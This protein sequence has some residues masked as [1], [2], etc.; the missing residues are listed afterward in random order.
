MEGGSLAV[1]LVTLCSPHPHGLDW[2]ALPIPSTLI[3]S[4]SQFQVHASDIQE[5][6]NT[7]IKTA[8]VWPG[9][10]TQCC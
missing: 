2:N 5:V 3:A 4:V 9:E 6:T 7:V 1:S 10:M 8:E